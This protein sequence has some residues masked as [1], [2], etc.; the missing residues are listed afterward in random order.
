MPTSHKPIVVVGSIN[1]DLVASS[2][3]LPVAGETV[4]GSSF[5]IHPGGKGANQAVAV[6][7]L[8]YPVQLIGKVGAD[9][10]G[11]Q[12]KSYL[13]SAGVDV[14]AVEV[15]A[16]TSGVA[17]IAV[18]PLGDNS[19]IVVPG[20]NAHVSPDFIDAHLEMI[21]RAGIVLTQLEIPIETVQHLA[22]L[23]WREGIPLMLDPAPA[24]DLPARVLSRLQWFTP[25]ETEATFFAAQSMDD[26]NPSQP[27]TVAD[28]LLAAGIH[29]VVLKMG[30]RGS[31]LACANGVAQLI[32]PYRV[33]AVD[34]TAAG[35]SFNGAFA[36][37]LM[38][39]MHEA[40]AAQF[41]SAA[42]AISVTRRGAQPSMPS[43][44]EVRRLH[45]SQQPHLELP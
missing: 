41:A 16:G 9:Q 34:T 36:T 14:S 29:G 39:D 26:G 21:R 40:S 13:R 28:T 20:A 30:S 44:D 37:A 25:N 43:W 17:M 32:P 33:T 23:C 22:E 3:R 31:Y 15:D 6:S 10:F 4:L 35:D 19:I 42:A 5:Q 11:E 24:Q 38:L 27:A 45:A 18:S 1:T 7:R 8:D 12:S 2:A